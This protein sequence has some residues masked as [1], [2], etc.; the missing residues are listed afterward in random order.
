MPL[1]P[2]NQPLDGGLKKGEQPDVR[3]LLLLIF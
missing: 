2:A 1:D 3:Y